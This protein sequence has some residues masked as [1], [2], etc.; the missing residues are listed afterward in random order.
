MASKKEILEI[1]GREVS[2][3]NP[4]KV[5]FPETGYTKMDLV[6][7]Y[8]AVAD[9]ALRGAG[10]RPMALKR[11]VDGD[12]EG[13]VLPEAGARQHARLDPDRRADVPVRPDR[14]R[15]RPR[16]AGR[17]RL[18]RQPRLHRPQPAPGPGRGPRPSR[19]APGRPRP[20]ARACRGRRSATSRWSAS[21]ALEAVGL[22]G[23][24]K[25]SGSRGH[26]H[27]RPDR[28]ALDVRRGPPGGARAGPRRRGAGAVDR[29]EQVVEGG[30]PRRLPRLQPERQGPDGRLGVLGPAA[31]RRPGLDAAPLGRGRRTSSPEDFTIATVPGDRRRARRRRRRDRRGRRVARRAARAERP[32][33]GR[34]R[35]RRAVAAELREAGRRAAAGPAVAGP[36]SEDRV[37]ARVAASR[38]GR[39]RR[40]RRSAPRPSRRA[41]PTPGC[42]PSG[43]ACRRRARRRSRPT[44]TGRRKTTIPVIEISRAA[45][46]EEALEGL[47]RWKAR[48][49]EAAA[50]PRAGRRPDRRD[51][52][53]LVALVPGPGQPDPRPGGGPAGPGGARPGLRPVGRL[54]VAR[55]QRPAGAGADAEVAA[56]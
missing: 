16:R 33:R 52:R 20:G 15:D 17:P 7:Y 31:A 32:P 3:S 34:G 6:S 48:H 14:R 2:I 22:V 5:Y 54:R 30:A 37:R 42:R 44:P 23:W 13:A 36:P 12:H 11:F 55:P 51:A 24:P 8:L 41:T 26:P 49:P 43:R 35:G 25:T 45:T 47:E 53:P 1:G 28:A 56:S 10:G 19:R 38:A 18:G 4:D 39:R 46:K 50:A 9:G 21:E 27:Q 40:S 29:D